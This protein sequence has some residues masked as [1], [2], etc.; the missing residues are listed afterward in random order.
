MATHP[1]TFQ[2]DAAAD[3]GSEELAR[4]EAY[5]LLAQLLY[6]PPAAAFYEQLQVATTQA[7]TPGGFLQSSWTEL[8]AASRR[9]TLAQVEAEHAAL[10]IGIGKPEVFLYGSYFMAGALNEKPL[11][12]LRHSLRELGLE[13][14]ETVTETED[15]IAALC[16]V[17]RYLIAGPDVAP[18]AL[19]VQQRFFNTHLRPWA[20]GLWDAMA[21]HPAAVFY[22]AV[23]VFARDFFAVEAQAFDLLEA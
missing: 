4:A 15:H 9:L 2:P 5:G 6:A 12:K 19:A 11:V 3:D 10:F 13:R 8:V 1:L 14:P 20:D 16:E 17:M 18:G 21:G 23:A 22:A 7:P